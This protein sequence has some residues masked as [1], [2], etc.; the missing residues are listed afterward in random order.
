MQ[1]IRVRTTQNV[2]IEY[3]LASIG[4][5]ILAYLLDGI[6]V[7]TYAIGI[8][9]LFAE[10][11]VERWYVWLIFIG[12]PWLFYSLAFEIFMDGQTPGK[13][14]LKIK[15]VRLDGTPPTIGDYLMRWICGFVDFYM[16]S[17]LIA[18][19]IITLGGKG[20]R[21]GDVAAGTSVVKLVDHHQ[22]SAENV[23]VSPEDDY[24]PT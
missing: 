17:G 13:Q 5:R 24:T 15:V 4:D 21:L 20:Q 9:A 10:L 14:V 16:F 12:F 2:F 1:T 3:P 8:V 7:F 19:L 6:I 18:V 23:F 11:D 22:I